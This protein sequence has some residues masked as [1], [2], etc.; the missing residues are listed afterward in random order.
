MNVCDT[1]ERERSSSKVA[2]T[3]SVIDI[4]SPLPWPGNNGPMRGMRHQVLKARAF[5]PCLMTQ[6]PQR[7][8]LILFPTPT[9]H[10]RFHQQ[11]DSYDLAH[12]DD[13]ITT[14][15]TNV[16]LHSNIHSKPTDT[17]KNQTAIRA[18]SHIAFFHIATE[19][20]LPDDQNFPNL[21]E[22]CTFQVSWTAYLT[23]TRPQA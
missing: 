13:S 5:S 18:F 20:R 21:G 14:T 6:P 9:S 19:L 17:T 11:Q 12:F 22:V 10:H 1:V 8:Q 4:G 15:H 16:Y 3:K 7:T 2:V 23:T